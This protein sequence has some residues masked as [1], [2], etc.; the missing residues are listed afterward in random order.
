M[1]IF[2][3][4]QVDTPDKI[5]RSYIRSA[6]DEAVLSISE[7]FKFEE[8]DRPTVDQDTQGVLGSP[9]IAETIFKKGV[10]T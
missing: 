4:W 6:I 8:A 2:Y 5:G 1:N 9:A 3:S 10:S 7:D